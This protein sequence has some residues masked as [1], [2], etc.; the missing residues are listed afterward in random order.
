MRADNIWPIALS[1]FVAKYLGSR[2]SEAV[3]VNWLLG[4]FSR[5][6]S[7]YIIR[8][9]FMVMKSMKKIPTMIMMKVWFNQV[10][11]FALFSSYLDVCKSISSTNA[12]KIKC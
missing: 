2:W 9:P 12:T 11:R 3:E 8:L 1:V 7:I 4:F 10:H 6:P 5:D